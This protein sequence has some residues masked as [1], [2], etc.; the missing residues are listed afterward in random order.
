VPSDAD[1]SKLEDCRK[2]V[3]A[4]LNAATRRAYD[5]VDSGKGGATR[6]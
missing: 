3:E 2:A 4:E 6:A 5:I 1:E